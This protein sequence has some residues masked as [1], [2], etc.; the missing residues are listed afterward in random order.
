MNAVGFF[1]LHLM[2]AGVCEGELYEE[3]TADGCKKLFTKENLLKGFILIGEEA[4]RRAG[5]YTALIREQ[6]PLDSIDFELMRQTAT[7]AAF[8]ETKRKDMFGGVKNHVD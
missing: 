1:G 7:S 3:K 8:S 2:T 5:L 6:T 4:T